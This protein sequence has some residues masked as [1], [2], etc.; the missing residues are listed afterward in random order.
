MSTALANAIENKIDR[1]IAGDIA[2]AQGGMALETMGEA[3]E[4]AKVMAISG[5]AVPPHCRNNPGLCLAVCIQ[6]LEWRMS[7]FAVANKSYVVND[8]L[9]YESQL[10]HAVIEQRAPIVSRLRHSFSGSGPTRRCKVWATAEGDSSP[11]EYESP[12]FLTILPKN[13]PL[14]KTKP[15]L[16]LYYNTSRDWARMYFPDVIMGVY[17]DDE[18]LDSPMQATARPVTIA[19]I[20]AQLEGPKSAEPTNDAPPASEPTSHEEGPQVE[21]DPLTVPRA[22]VEEFKNAK[23]YAAGQRTYDRLLGPDNATEWAPEI[24]EGIEQLWRECQARFAKPEQGSLLE[25]K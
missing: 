5:T 7:P 18:M 6:S 21:P 17:S 1:A 24:I 12:E 9:S 13:S 16:Q 8:R 22:I 3:M 20:T 23:S 15:D 10:I 11:L 19:A 25:G 4:F 2:L 14:W